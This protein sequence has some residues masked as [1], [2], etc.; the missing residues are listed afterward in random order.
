MFRNIQIRAAVLLTVGLLAM[1]AA[2]AAATGRYGGVYRVPLESEPI[3]LDPHRLTGIYAMN[4]ANDLFDGLVAFDNNLNVVPVIAKIWKISR[5]H[6]TYTFRLR[7]GVSFH[8]GRQVTAD[9]FV[10]SFS[11]ILDPEVKSP[12]MSLFLNIRG[13]QEFHDGTA[14][15]VAGLRA[16]DR[17]TLSIELAEPFAPFLSI[18]A[19]VNAKVVPKEDVNPDFGQHP[20]GTGPFVFDSWRPG[21][22]ITLSANAAYF[23]GRPFLNALQFQI[24]PNIEWERVFEKFE[25]GHLEQALIPS[26]KFDH[27]QADADLKTRFNLV[28]RSGF[29]LVYVG[30]NMGMDVFKD[31]RVRQALYYA[32]DREAITQDITRRNSKPAKGILP[33]GIPGHDPRAEWYTYDP[34][35]A[36]ELLAEA[37]YPDGV[38]IPPLEVWTVSKSDSVQSELKAYQRYL[39]DVG[40]QLIP[41][42]AENWKDFIDLINDK[43]AAMFYAAWYADFPD[44]DNFLY[45][46]CHSNSRTNRM[47]YS[48]PLVDRML[49]TARGEMDYMKRVAQYREIENLVMLDAPLIAQHHNSFNYVFQPWVKGVDI[50]HLGATYLPF[51][52]IWIE[53]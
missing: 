25:N 41:K 24:F 21:L 46:L 3:T 43:K 36:K 17:H 51:R 6:R 13:A 23:A 27:F 19:M 34:E 53:R 49:E 50:N 47:G 32:V 8:N 52:T 30:L 40:I 14:D 39:A 5:D 33:P 20:V 48:N 2:P 35:R 11:R 44:P 12:A 38:G 1:S 22:D 31:R 9:D 16:P 26:G 15:T 18:L 4:V 7:K 28:G 42:V 37:G 45:V 10:Y 29:N